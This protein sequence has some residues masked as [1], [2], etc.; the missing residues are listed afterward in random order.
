MAQSNRMTTKRNRLTKIF[1]IVCTLS[2]I[3]LVGCDKKVPINTN[4][5]S[6]PTVTIKVNGPNGYQEQTS[7]D[8]TNST[9]QEAIDIMA[10]VEDPQGVKSIKLLVSD[11]TVDVAYCGGGLHPGNHPVADLPVPA[12]MNVSGSSGKVPTKIFVMM[13]IPKLLKIETN[14][15]G[16]TGTCYPA[17][18]TQI[19]LKCVGKNWSSN[20]TKST[21]I[22][23]LNIKFKI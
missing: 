21:N 6:N 16:E 17:N 3:M 9:S 13:T 14:P 4:D 19:S 5:S 18:N 23:Y 11:K 22:K 12:E 7:V 1:A 15:P 8:H 2:L 10:I 20:P